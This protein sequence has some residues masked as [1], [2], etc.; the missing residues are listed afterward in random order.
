MNYN[1]FLDLAKQKGLDNI[2]I[3]ATTVESIEI[4][5]IDE[6]LENYVNTNHIDYS[7]KAEK[8]KKTETLSSDYL[9]EDIIDLLLMKIDN[10]DSNYENEYLEKKEIKDKKTKIEVDADKEF[11]ILKNIYKYKEKDKRISK[12]TS[13][14]EDSYVKTNIINSNGANLE[15]SSHN[16]LFYI[17][18]LVED[19]DEGISYDKQVLKTNKDDINFE[20]IINNTIDEALMM[21][22]KEDLKT[23]KYNVVL[24][25]KVASRILSH[26]EDMLNQNNIRTKTSCMC[27]K[28][29]EKIFNDNITIIEDQPNEDY[30]GFR[31]FDD[32]GTETKTKLVVENGILK[33]HFSNIKEA[34]INNSKSTGNGYGNISTRNMYLKPSTEKY[35]DIFAKLKDGIYITDYMGS[36]NTAIS[37]TTGNIS[38]QIF[39]FIVKNGKIKCGFNPCIMTTT[40]FELFNSVKLIGDTIE[41]TNKKAASP[42]LL[43]ENISIA[44]SN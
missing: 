40:I 2:Q 29:N 12:I 30:P 33:T 20:K 25:T 39:G 9:D 21:I 34:K 14:Y 17:D 10:T 28:F 26:L 24:S 27:S 1:E 8:D 43:V 5:F 13:A 19:N 15:T 31:L 4:E 35:D 22:N 36:S 42:L 32:E 18:V 23:K 7:I 6:K 44:S 16:Y 38:I 11:M 37:T 41:F 3:T